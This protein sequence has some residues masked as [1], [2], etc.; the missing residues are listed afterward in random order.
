MATVFE[1]VAVLEKA[2]ITQEI[3]EVNEPPRLIFRNTQSGKYRIESLDSSFSR[4]LESVESS[5]YFDTALTTKS[6]RNELKIYFGV[7]VT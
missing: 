2:P 1:V 6:W 7:G 4:R 3:L 5:T